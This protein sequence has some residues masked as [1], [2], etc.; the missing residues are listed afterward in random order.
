MALLGKSGRTPHS[1]SG[2]W[3]N[4]LQLHPEKL[5]NPWMSRILVWSGQSFLVVQIQTG[6]FHLVTPNWTITSV[7]EITLIMWNKTSQK[8]IPSWTRKAWCKVPSVGMGLDFFVCIFL[9]TFW[10]Q[11][12]RINHKSKQDH[13]FQKPSD[14]A[15]V[16]RPSIFFLY[17]QV[18]LV[19]LL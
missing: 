1:S 18:V 16:C 11:E 5:Q 19:L 12:V 6:V 4:M 10:I 17:V 2:N 14:R 13:P 8:L 3:S 9:M 15:E 7:K